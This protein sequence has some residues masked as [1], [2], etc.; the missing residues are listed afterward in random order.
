MVVMGNGSSSECDLCFS[1]F[2]VGKGL[3]AG[4]SVLGLGALCYYGLGMS[5]EVGAIDRAG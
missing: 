5:N 3:V 1:A 2:T 4:S